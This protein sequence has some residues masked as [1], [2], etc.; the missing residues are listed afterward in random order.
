MKRILGLIIVLVG[1]IGL[2]ISIAGTMISFRFV[3]S[4]G[5]GVIDTLQLTAESLVTVEETLMLTKTTIGQMNDGLETVV[6]TADNVSSAIRQT[7]PLLDQISGVASTTVPDSLEAFQ[8]TIPNLVE[9][10]GVIDSTLRTLSEIRIQ[11]ALGPF[12][13]DF[14]LG[15]EYDPETPFDESIA[16]LGDTLDGVPE[17]LR[18]LDVYLDV[19]ANNLETIS[20]DINDLADNVNTINSS[21]AE[22][23]PLIDDYLMIVN[24]LEQTIDEMETGI[25][26]NLQYVKTGLLVLFIWFG[27]N[28]IMPLY[29]GWELLSG[30]RDD[31]QPEKPAGDEPEPEV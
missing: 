18:S 22:I 31:D 2:V 26:T 5:A 13:I 19:T 15:V 28:Q 29:F 8:E 17:Q 24:D 4:L 20:N 30:R 27:L 23:I 14:D 25:S 11:R 16:A 7:E 6:V 21:V 12:D 9:V 3:D 10:A 1:I